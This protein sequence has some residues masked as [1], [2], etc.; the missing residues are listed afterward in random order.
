[1]LGGKVAAVVCGRSAQ[2]RSLRGA[3]LLYEA[4]FTLAS[5]A[6]ASG[7]IYATVDVTNV[8]IS[9]ISWLENGE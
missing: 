7:R 2:P 5:A 9:V 8:N 1:M 6:S 3:W 4:K